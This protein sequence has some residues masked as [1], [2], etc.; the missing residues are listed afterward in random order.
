MSDK[1]KSVLE[2]A[3]ASITQGDYEAFL[4][5]CTED[6]EW[7]FIGDFILKG[8]DA[9]RQWMAETYIEP[10]RFE[11][12]RLIAEDDFVVAMGEI[13]LKDKE[14]KETSSSYCDV[15]RFRDHKMSEPRAFVRGKLAGSS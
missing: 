2:K 13:T 9:V 4:S 3:N 5:F 11:V 10:P 8:K 6:T 1:N 14:G 7:T 15:W 12:K